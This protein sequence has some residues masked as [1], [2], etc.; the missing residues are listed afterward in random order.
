MGGMIDPARGCGN[1]PDAPEARSGQQLLTS[2]RPAEVPAV[3]MPAMDTAETWSACGFSGYGLP[4]DRAVVICLAARSTTHCNDQPGTMNVH[5]LNKFRKTVRRLLDGEPRKPETNVDVTNAETKT[6]FFV[7]PGHFYSPLPDRDDAA[8]ALDK[9]EAAV[10]SALPGV[11]IDD[12]AMREVW[13]KLRPFMETAP[14]P[15]AKTDGHRYHFDNEFFSYGDALVYYAMLGLFRPRRMIEIGSGYS[16]A[17]ALD[18]REQLKLDLHLSFVEPYP[19]ILKSLIKP[20]EQANCE[21]LEQKVQTVALA[22][23]A[24]LEANDILFIDS[25]HVAKTGSDVCFELFEILPALKSGVL[26]HIH[27]MFWPF[28]YFRSWVLDDKRAWN[29]LYFVRAFL[30]HNPDYQI[31]FFN[32]YFAKLHPGDVRTSSAPFQRNPGGG[33]W[34]RKR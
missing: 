25:S 6:D 33:L 18:A 21:L 13:Q 29:E 12:A 2:A 14:F 34:L 27:D 17:L 8:Q 31:L 11:V 3:A 9:A 30:M 15:Q 16:S 7:P 5:R 26:I 24:A 1:F 32:D 4:I 20:A 10:P 22:R 19:A 28:E 23:F